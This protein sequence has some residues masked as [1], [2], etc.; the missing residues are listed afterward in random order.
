[1]KYNTEKCNYLKLRNKFID[2]LRNR[3]FLKYLLAKLFQYISYS[4][5]KIT[6]KLTRYCVFQ[7]CSGNADIANASHGGGGNN[8]Q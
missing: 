1:M 7:L 5:E 4:K 2:L 8:Q 6:L 3:G